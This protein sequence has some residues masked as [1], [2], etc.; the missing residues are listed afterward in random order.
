[1]R[2]WPSLCESSTCEGRI[3][4]EL[5]Y[6]VPANLKRTYNLPGEQIDERGGW[7]YRPGSTEK[8][9]TSCGKLLRPQAG[10]SKDPARPSPPGNHLS[11]PYVISTGARLPQKNGSMR[12]LPPWA[13][14]ASSVLTSMLLMA[15]DPTSAV[16]S[17]TSSSNPKLAV[18]TNPRP[19]VSADDGLSILAA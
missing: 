12:R 13:I 5:R 14:L 17:A 10:A 16:P 8:N 9:S 7:N 18:R 3:R 4:T 19:T 6:R 1:W 11:R 15:Q 2:V